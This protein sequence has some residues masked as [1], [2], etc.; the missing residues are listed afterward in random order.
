MMVDMRCTQLQKIS[1]EKHVV[2]G[3]FSAIKGGVLDNREE[4]RG[5]S[6]RGG[7]NDRSGQSTA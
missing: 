1:K 7:G 4:G 5:Q 3:H 2:N 6:T